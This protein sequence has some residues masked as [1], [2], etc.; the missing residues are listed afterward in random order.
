MNSRPKL[1]LA[2][3]SPRRR[4][5]LI[6]HGYVFEVIPPDDEHEDAPAAGET[7][8]AYVARLAYAKAVTVASRIKSGL[9]LACDTVAELE[10]QIFGKPK[11]ADHARQMLLALNGQVHFVHS[12]VCLCDVSSGKQLI[13]VDTTALRMDTLSAEQLNNYLDSGEWEGKA[14]AFGFQDRLDWVYIVDGSETNVV[15]L[16]MERLQKMLSSMGFEP[17]SL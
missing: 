17:P 1:V 14:G 13:E 7:S 6:E 11:N 3:R 5:L 10:G 15:G 8:R 2:S 16:P 9:V 12:G 4:Q